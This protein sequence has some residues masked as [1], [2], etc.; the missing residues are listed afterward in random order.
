MSKGF[1]KYFP[2]WLILFAGINATAWIMP[3]IRSKAFWTVFGIVNAAWLIQLLLAFFIFNEKKEISTPAFIPSF[4]S[5]I[6]L[7]TVDAFGLYYFWEPWVLALVSMIIL[8]VTYLF[9][10]IVVQNTAN[11]VDRDENVKA[12]TAT[13]NELI[14]EVKVLYNNTN[15]QDI[16]RLY[17][18]LKYSDKGTK[19]TEIENKIAEEVQLLKSTDENNISS[20]VDSIIELINKR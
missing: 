6:V 16:Y 11:A 7:F 19:N 13:M 12:K 14:K 10:T 20:S 2:V 3:L 18:A 15:N 9:M 5:L 17:E 8:A 4:I 1:K